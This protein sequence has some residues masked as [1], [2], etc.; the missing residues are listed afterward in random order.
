MYYRYI[1]LYE[2]IIALLQGIIAPLIPQ[3]ISF[4]DTF[5]S[6]GNLMLALSIP[7]KFGFYHQ[8]IWANIIEIVASMKMQLRCTLCGYS[9]KL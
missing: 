2:L 1:M 6:I 7:H 9:M 4:D 5:E 8:F 3:F